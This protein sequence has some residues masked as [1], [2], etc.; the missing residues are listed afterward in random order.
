[1]QCTELLEAAPP[2]EATTRLY[3][4]IQS[5]G[6]STQV[7]R[8]AASPAATNVLPPLPALIVGR[9]H[10]LDDLKQR[11]GMRHGAL[12]PFTCG[13]RRR[14]TPDLGRLS[15]VCPT[16]DKLPQRLHHSRT[17]TGQH[18]AIDRKRRPGNPGG[19]GAGEEQDRLDHVAGLAMPAERLE[20]V[21]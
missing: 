17:A 12:R 3:I 15:E 2:E 18:P 9:E 4:A 10:P 11:V 7:A 16:S 8:R 6:R 13:R 19:L 1:M 21:E 5:D 14:R 20:R